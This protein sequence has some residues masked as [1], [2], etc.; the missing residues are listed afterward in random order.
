MLEERGAEAIP[1][2]AIR[3]IEEYLAKKQRNT[4]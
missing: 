2:H 4:T 1:A 3:I